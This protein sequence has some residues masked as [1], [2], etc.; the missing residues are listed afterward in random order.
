M[1]FTN[2][3]AGV[4]FLVLGAFLSGCSDSSKDSAAAN[5]SSASSE[6]VI[7]FG[8]CPGPYS[9]MVSDF[10]EKELNRQGYKVEY[11]EF[12]DYVQPDS[13]LDSGNIDAGDFLY[14]Q[15]LNILLFLC[16]EHRFYRFYIH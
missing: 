10:F 15:C 2:K 6:K 13:A 8:F 9:R 16:Y 14:L 3:T 11:V 4:L 7:R 12:T 5:S 1:Y